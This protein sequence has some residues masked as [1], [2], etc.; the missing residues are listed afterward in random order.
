MGK[1]P[2]K[3]IHKH[4]KIHK[5]HSITLQNPE[6]K[7]TSY[8]TQI[9]T[10]NPYKFYDLC[11]VNY[12][13]RTLFHYENTHKIF[14]GYPNIRTGGDKRELFVFRDERKSFTEKG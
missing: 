11:L 12:R 6:N 3:T 9:S 10:Q 1:T 14:L 4:T 5:A 13:E 7:K 8:K 2:K